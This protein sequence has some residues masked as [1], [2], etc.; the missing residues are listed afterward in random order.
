[1]SARFV[2]YNKNNKGAT[3][4][5]DYLI[6]VSE[7]EEG[8]GIFISPDACNTREMHPHTRAEYTL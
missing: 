2:R 5:K 4:S 6:K 1:M 8:N 3:V 7:P